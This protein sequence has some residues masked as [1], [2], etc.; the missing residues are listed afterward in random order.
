MDAPWTTFYEEGVPKSIVYP[1]WTLPDLLDAAAREFPDKIA[2]I[3]G[4]QSRLPPA[5]LQVLL[6]VKNQTFLHHTK[7]LGLLLSLCC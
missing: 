7:F 3:S 4:E 2:L 6:R 1:D 5:N